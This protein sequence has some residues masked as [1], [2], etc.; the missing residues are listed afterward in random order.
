[1]KWSFEYLAYPIKNRSVRRKPTAIWNGIVTAGRAEIFV[2]DLNS[3]DSPIEED[4]NI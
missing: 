2:A 1:M 4:L 3:H